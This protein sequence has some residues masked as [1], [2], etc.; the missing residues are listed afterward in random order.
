MIQKL[1]RYLK[2]VRALQRIN[3]SLAR[4]AATSSLRTIDPTNPSSWEFSGFSQNGED[5]ILDELTRRLRAPNRYFVEIGASDG[6]ENNTTWLALGRRFSGLWIEGDAAASEWCRF[7]LG[8]LNYGVDARCLFVTRDRAAELRRTVVHADPDVFSLDIDGNDYHLVQA[9]LAAGLR[10]KIWVVEYNSAYGPERRV[11]IPYRED[12]RVVPETNA[13]LYYG[14]SIAAWRS[15][16]ERA[17]YHFVTVDLNGVNGFFIDPAAFAPA[18]VDGLRGVP[19]LPN[20]SHTREYG[21]DW[22]GQLERIGNRELID[23]E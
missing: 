14:C 5:G 15:L 7:L 20:T 9:L 16:F 1:I 6:L 19:Y 4:A 10:P 17:G 21:V 13:N 3:L 8:P 11:T 22:R 23:V 2:Q 18:F 12:F